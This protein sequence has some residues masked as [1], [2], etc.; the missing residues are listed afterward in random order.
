MPTRRVR[1]TVRKPVRMKRGGS[2]MVPYLGKQQRAKK[3][4]GFKDWIKTS[5]LPWLKRELPIAAA[6][7]NKYIS[8]NKI[9]SSKMREFAKNNAELPYWGNTLIPIAAMGVEALGYGKKRRG[10]KMIKY[11]R[12]KG[13]GLG[14]TGGSKNKR[15][16]M[17]GRK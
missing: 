12:K 15:G 14:H 2:M 8:D 11:R 7:G 5:A 4:A 3:W 1:K 9:I 16:R 13:S 6:A 17:R 10:A